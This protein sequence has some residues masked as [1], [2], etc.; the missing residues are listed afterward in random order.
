MMIKFYRPYFIYEYKF[1]CSLFWTS[2]KWTNDI[3]TPLGPFKHFHFYSP[4]TKSSK[5]GSSWSIKD[6]TDDYTDE[7]FRKVILFFSYKLL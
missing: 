1:A 5:T 2:C 6:Y 7:D 3:K 4:H